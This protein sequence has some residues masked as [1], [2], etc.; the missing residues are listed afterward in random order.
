MNA[1]EIKNLSYSYGERKALRDVSFSVPAGSFFCLLGP[2]GGGKSTLLKILSTLE[3]PQTGSVEIFGNPLKGKLQALRSQIGIV[4]QSPALDKKLSVFENLLH[5]GHLYGLS[6]KALQ[7]RCDELLNFMG[8]A[9]RKDDRSESLSGGLNRRVE[10]AKSLIHK[11]KLLILDEPTTGLDPNIRREIWRDL[12][13]QQELENLTVL[14]TT[15]LLEEADSS[16]RVAMLDQGRLVAEGTPQELKALLGEETVSLKSRNSKALSERI[17]KELGLEALLVEDEVRL[18]KG[19]SKDNLSLL[20][21][22]FREQYDS[23]TIGRPTLEDLFMQKTG[24][25]MTYEEGA[26]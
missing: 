19:I 5:H 16:G 18:Q 22:N 13:R 10:I 4:F 20:L 12:K 8:L 2:N 21:Q 9:D 11:P 24:R 25:R 26:T 7:N 6:G 3:L 14:F 23:L 1:I 15:H 17:T